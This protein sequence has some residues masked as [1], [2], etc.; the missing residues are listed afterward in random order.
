M[1]T[2]PRRR[3]LPDRISNDLKNGSMPEVLQMALG[4]NGSYFVSYR[5]PDGGFSLCESSVH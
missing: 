5:R 2:P 4:A 3:G 1:L